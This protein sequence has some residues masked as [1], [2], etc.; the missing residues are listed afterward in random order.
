MCM[1]GSNLKLPTAYC[2]LV[3]LTFATNSAN[4]AENTP[5]K[6]PTKAAMVTII[7]LPRPVD[8]MDFIGG[9]TSRVLLKFASCEL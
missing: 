5:R 6:I 3:S 7:L 1:Y 9:R 8:S 4:K 2:L